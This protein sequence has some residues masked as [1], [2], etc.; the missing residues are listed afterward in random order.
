VS[1]VVVDASAL[2]AIGRGEPGYEVL[3]EHLVEADPVVVSAATIV[4][5]SMVL[6]S[7]LGAAG[8]GFLARELA[9]GR[10]S[11]LDVTVADSRSAVDAWRT[12]GKGNHR[13]ALNFGDC[14]VYALAER[15][16]YPILCT[17][18]D[19]AQTDLEVLPP[20]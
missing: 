9:R 3:V 10:V 7:R 19:F 16:G 6:I 8:E 17:G 12:Y 18:N 1:G 20:R 13:A 11:V 14:F 2:I 15:T 5:A 4:E